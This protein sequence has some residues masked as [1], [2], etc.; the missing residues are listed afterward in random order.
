MTM[1]SLLGLPLDLP[2]DAPARADGCT[3]FWS[4]LPEYLSRCKCFRTTASTTFEANKYT[5]AKL[6]RE[7]YLLRRRTK[8]TVLMRSAR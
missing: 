8:P 1:I 4:G 6:S 5:Q 7:G 2:P 3:S